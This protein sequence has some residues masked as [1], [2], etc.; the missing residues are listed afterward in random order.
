MNTSISGF[1]PITVI[2]KLIAFN[3]YLRPK[4]N[5]VKGVV[6]RSQARAVLL[7]QAPVLAEKGKLSADN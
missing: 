5:K 3:N 6:D 2:C 4:I 7:P 1:P